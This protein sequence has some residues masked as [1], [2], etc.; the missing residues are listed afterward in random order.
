[1]S[2]IA[3]GIQMLTYSGRGMD[4]LGNIDGCLGLPSNT[5]HY[6]VYQSEMDIP[7]AGSMS[8][9]L[10]LCL[11]PS[12]NTT[13]DISMAIQ[14]LSQVGAVLVKPGNDSVSHCYA[15]YDHVTV[16]EWTA[17]AGIMVGVCLFFSLLVAVGTALEVA[18]MTMM[19]TRSHK[20]DVVQQTTPIEESEQRAGPVPVKR[21]PILHALLAFSLVSNYK[22]FTNG[23]STK[24][25]LD[26]LDGIRTLST[27]WV[28]LGHSLVF[29]M[30][31]GLDNVSYVFG[32]ARRSFAFQVFMAGEFSVD[33]FFMLS[34]FLVAYTVLT[35]MD[36]RQGKTGPL[37]W[38]MY[39]VHRFIRLSPLYYFIV[40]FF[41]QVSPL[42]GSGPLWF[43]YRD[44]VK[45]CDQYWWTNLLYINNMYP[46]KL[47]D[48]CT[49][50][51][52]YLAN[53]MQ[54]YLLV[55]IVLV[56]FYW[57]RCAGWAL[58]CAILAA[59]FT[60]NIWVAAKYEIPTFF[61]FAASP[62]GFGQDLYQR[63]WFR[64]GAYVVG[65]AVAFL[66]R[67][68]KTK[69]LYDM[70]CFRAVAYVASLV[71]TFFFAY[72][73]YTSFHSENGW[74][75]TENSL[76]NGF[77]HTM[78]PLGV[79]IFMM[80]TFYGHGGVV[81][82][83]LEHPL[84]RYLSKLTYSTYLVHPIVM[85]VHSYSLTTYAHYSP[86]EF[87]WTFVA[88]LVMSFAAAFV[89]HLTIERPFMNIERMVFGGGGGSGKKEDGGE[90][91]SSK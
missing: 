63:P 40:F 22:S 73:P 4:D 51:G 82:L 77:A 31:P 8:Y 41:W 52:W 1:M 67:E 7:V 18:I 66:Y 53:D 64:M 42:L 14:Q 2:N 13:T 16:K 48:E 46:V 90:S 6:C 17:G 38:L 11:P 72:I 39:V 89:L 76:F 24:R 43:L 54:F 70:P 56:V 79:T 91:P 62:D 32:V 37:F 21:S 88:N 33:V 34:G 84:F 85:W 3:V 10:G 61:E 55:P 20:N 45:T 30:G 47:A 26:S 65:V 25:Y 81:A 12:C 58:V 5:S 35:Q 15:D 60:S 9:T 87:T 44:T 78:L 28:V 68:P 29:L 23:R 75:N 71:I 19:R 86:I 74:N 59:C 80:A 50:W 57:R 69:E 36:K 49:G 83:F 27:C